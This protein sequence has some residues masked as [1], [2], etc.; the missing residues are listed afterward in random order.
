MWRKYGASYVYRS[1]FKKNIIYCI[2]NELVI[3]MYLYILIICLM[4][5]MLALKIINII[6]WIGEYVYI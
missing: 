5:L 1:A 6:H 2:N 3:N 4:C